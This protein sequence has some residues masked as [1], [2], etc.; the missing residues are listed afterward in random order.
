MAYITDDI[1]FP[2]QFSVFKTPDRWCLDNIGMARLDSCTHDLAFF[3]ILLEY[4]SAYFVSDGFGNPYFEAERQRIEYK[5]QYS[6]MGGNSSQMPCLNLDVRLWLTEPRLAIPTNPADPTSRV[7]VLKTESGGIFYRYKTIDYDFYAQNIVT[8]NMDILFLSDARGLSTNVRR[9]KKSDRTTQIITAGLDLNVQYDMHID[10]NHMNI[11]V[12]TSIPDPCNDELKGIESSHP[13]VEPLLLP[14]PTVCHPRFKFSKRSTTLFSC[15]ITMSPEDLQMAGNLLY[16]FAG[17]YEPVNEGVSESNSGNSTKEGQKEELSLSATV[18]LTGI[19]LV[20]CEPILGMHLPI[21]NIYIS[22]LRCTVSDFKIE[23]CFKK[24]NMDFQGCADAQLWVDY[25]KS[26]PTRSWEPLLEPYKCT[27]LYEKSAHR[28][29]GITV[30]SETPFHLN[31]SGAF[32]ETFDFAT[33]SFFTSIFKMLEKESLPTTPPS[34]VERR[35]KASN[36]SRGQHFPRMAKEDVTSANGDIISV[37]HEQVPTLSSEELLAFS[38]INLTGERIRFHQQNSPNSNFLVGYLD[39]LDVTA[40]SFPAT[41]SVFRNLK[42]VE[43]SSE[44][45]DDG[46]VAPGGQVD[47]SH[48]IELQVPGMY[49]C[50]AICVDNPGKRFVNLQPRSDAMMVSG[51]STFD[52]KRYFSLNDIFLSTIPRQKFKAIGG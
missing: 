36:T 43:V 28:G 34:V 32:L 24:E 52:S 47:S 7:L 21:A 27:V 26:G 10:T 20:I 18:K 41:R 4:F 46:E 22:E 23:D 48:Y 13:I 50:R 31:I 5:Q 11:F 14:P 45:L 33:N 8:Q 44:S 6:Q 51:V 3:W 49:W 12:S 42:V 38:L 30:N 29:L 19:R 35:G 2:F 37:T 1:D 16:N 40:L 17:P 39:N 15:D 9:M 25:Y